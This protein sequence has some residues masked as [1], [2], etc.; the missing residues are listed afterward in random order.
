[1]PAFKTC[2]Q[3]YDLV[4]DRWPE[5]AAEISVAYATV[6]LT[7]P[8]SVSLIIKPVRVLS[9]KYEKVSFMFT[10]IAK[11]IS[12]DWR[13]KEGNI[14]TCKCNPQITIEPIQLNGKHRQ[15]FDCSGNQCHLDPNALIS[16]HKK[17]PHRICAIDSHILHLH[18]YPHE[19]EDM[20]TII[21][22]VFRCRDNTDYAYR[23]PLR[24][25]AAHRSLRA[26]RGN[27]MPSA[28]DVWRKKWVRR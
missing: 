15:S 20:C 26:P 12:F 2:T 17:Q 27:A 4:K 8:G 21:D 3:I 13:N 19:I 6:T 22:A 25:I 7:F 5:I 28:S 14:F 9:S 18:Y 10:D 1:M 24:S 16:A 23:A 11:I